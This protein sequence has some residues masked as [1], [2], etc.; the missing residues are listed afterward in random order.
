MNPGLWWS[1]AGQENLPS[2]YGPADLAGAATGGREET[3]R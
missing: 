2:P 3:G 1:Y